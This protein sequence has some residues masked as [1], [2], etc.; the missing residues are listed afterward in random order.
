[1]RVVVV[2]M[3]GRQEQEV[4]AKKFKNLDI[5]FANKGSRY[6]LSQAALL[7]NA[8]RIYVMTKFVSHSLTQGL[9]RAKTVMLHGGFSTLRKALATLNDTV[10]ATGAP[11]LTH[12]E[13]T[14]ED[15]PEKYDFSAITK[16]AVSDVL[17]F[18]RAPD[19]T[20]KQWELK[21]TGARS[22]YKRSKGINSV[23]ET[24]DG[25]VEVL[26]T[27]IPAPY[28]EKPPAQETAAAAVPGSSKS[29]FWQEV[30]MLSMHQNPG[31]SVAEHASR[32]SLATSMCPE[33]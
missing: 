4:G 26:I 1:M 19:C 14:E 20:M 22:Y 5:R 30:F 28:S 32:A 9:D 7:D 3:L 24:K 6:G 21:V 31:M 10:G 11:E 2:G 25:A 16:A 18:P 8:D 29:K 27:G 33:E 15:M 23:Q 12:Q 13:Q 17:V